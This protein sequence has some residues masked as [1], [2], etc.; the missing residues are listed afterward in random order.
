M[1]KAISAKM[2]RKCRGNMKVTDFCQKYGLL[3]SNVYNAERN[4]LRKRTET[5]YGYMEAKKDLKPKTV[6]R[7]AR[8]LISEEFNLSFAGFED[9]NSTNTAQVLAEVINSS[10]SRESKKTREIP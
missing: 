4:G 5:Y 9:N 8:P 7:K 1:T 6:L 10:L 2:A 3:S